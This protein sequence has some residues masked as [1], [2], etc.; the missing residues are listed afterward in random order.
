MKEETRKYKQ[1]KRQAYP[2]QREDMRQ[3]HI[4]LDVELQLFQD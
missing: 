2:L 1:I 3:L 4:R